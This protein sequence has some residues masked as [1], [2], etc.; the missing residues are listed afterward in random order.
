MS[1]FSWV[2]VML[3]S[4]VFALCVLFFSCQKPSPT[5]PTKTAESPT[6]TQNQKPQSE[7]PPN[8]AA[9]ANDEFELFMLTAESSFNDGKYEDAIARYK[10]AQQIKADALIYFRL[11][12]AYQKWGLSTKEKVAR[13]ERLTQAKIN[14]DL[15]LQNGGRGAEAEKAKKALQEIE[16]SLSAK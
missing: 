12:E 14:F 13:K 8:A 1:V 5:Q 6:P 4:H 10:S 11:G 15:F 3:K 9:L 2:L 7:P 16:K